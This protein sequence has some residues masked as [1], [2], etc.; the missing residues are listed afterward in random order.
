MTDKP[1]APDFLIKA[2]DPTTG[3]FRIVGAGWNAENTFGKYI[4]LAIGDGANRKTYLMDTAKPRSNTPNAGP[5]LVDSSSVQQP[6]P[7][8]DEPLPF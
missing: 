7:D 4:S 5:P 6:I 2:K 1:N 3:K 8:L